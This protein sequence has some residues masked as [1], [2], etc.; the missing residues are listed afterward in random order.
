M[1][2]I[3]PTVGE[4]DPSLVRAVLLEELGRGSAGSRYHAGI[5]RSARTIE[6]RREQPLATRAGKVLP[7]HLLR[8]SETG[9]APARR[10][11]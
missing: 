11:G 7:F 10:D 8:R 1:L 3:S 4:L 5:W 2:R 9:S 6:V